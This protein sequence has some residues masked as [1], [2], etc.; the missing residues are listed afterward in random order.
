MRIFNT[1][2]RTL[3]DF[4][5]RDAGQVTMYVCGATVQSKPHVGHGRYAV[6]FDVVRR[7]FEW[8]GYDVTYVRNITD[9]DDKINARAAE[10]YPGRPLNNAIAEVT[11]RTIVVREL[12]G[13]TSDARFDF[14]INGVRAGYADYEVIRDA[15]AA[16]PQEVMSG[17]R[18][19][20]GE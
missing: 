15:D 5:P 10:E 6:V 16:L 14:L 19:K 3:Q 13:G 11:T 4:E 20:T 1:L 9:V 12:M 2:G 17:E 8:L 18:A 7:Y